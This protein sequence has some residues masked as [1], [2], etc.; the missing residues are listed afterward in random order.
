MARIGE[1]P[2]FWALKLQCDLDVGAFTLPHAAPK[3]SIQPSQ[4]QVSG[5]EVSMRVQTLAEVYFAYGGFPKLG[6]LFGCPYYKDHGSWGLYW[7][8]PIL[9]NYH[10]H[11]FMRPYLKRR[12]VILMIWD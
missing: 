10:I 6:V 8:P 3:P 1:N 2:I 4:L 9:G 11:A 5:F 7:G 12:H